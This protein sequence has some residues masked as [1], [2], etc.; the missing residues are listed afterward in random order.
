MPNSNEVSIVNFPVPLLFAWGFIKS[1]VN[2][3]PSLFLSMSE[4]IS[5]KYEDWFICF[6]ESKKSAIS[7]LL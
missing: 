1:K 7:V 5:I 4:V 3:S 2:L 6:R